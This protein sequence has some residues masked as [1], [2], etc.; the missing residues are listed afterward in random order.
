MSEEAYIFLP[1]FAQQRLWFIDQLMPGT[2][3]YNLPTTM[4]LAGPLDVAALARSLRAITQRHETTRTTFTTVDGAL[5]QVVTPDAAGAPSEPSLPLLDLQALPDAPRAGAVRA[6]ATAEARRPFD[7]ARGPLLRVGLLRLG[8]DEHVLL[9]TMHHI[10]SDGWS[11]GVLVRELVTLYAA[12]ASGTPIDL[13]ELPIQYSDYAHW[14][15]EWLQG[16]LLET[17]LAYWK[18][19]LAGAPATLELPTDRPRSS[20]QSFHGARRAWACAEPLLDA[21]KRLSQQS[22]TTLFMTLLAGF[23]SLLARYSGQHDTVV[24]TPIA[25]RIQGET[26]GVL[27]CFVNTLVL[28]GDLAGNPTFREFVGRVRETALA[29]YANQDV[30]FELVVEALRPARELSY[31]PLFQV[32]FALQNL[33][34][35]NLD[36]PGLQLRPLDFGRETAMF[37]LNMALEESRGGLRGTLEYASELFDHTTIMRMLGHFTTLLASVAADP[38]RRLADLPLLTPIER[39]QLLVEWNATLF[40]YPRDRCLHQLFEAQAART[41]DAVALVY[42]TRD[43]GRGTKDEGS[44]FVVRPSSFVAHLT[45]AELDRRANQLARHLRM[46]GVGPQ[47]LVTLC[48]ER[49][50]ELVVGLLGVLKAG[51]AFLPLDPAYPLARLN[52]MLEDSQAAVLITMSDERRATSDEGANSSS[53]LRPASCVKTVDLAADWPL[54]AQQPPTPPAS[55]VG[56]ADLAY[57][58]YTSGST[59]QP[60]GVPIRHG[61]AVPFFLWYQEYFGLRA[62]DRVIQ[63]HSLSFDFSTWEIFE[64]LIVGAALY[65][66]PGAVAQDVGALADALDDARIS[67]L[68]MTPS[69]FSALCDYVEQFKPS[70]LATTRILVLGGEL[71]PMA[72]A[73]RAAQII[74]DG[75]R[76]YN[77]Y[78]PTETTISSAIFRVAPA[79]LAHAD[80]RPGVPIGPPIGN[81][82]FYLLDARFQPVPI[83]L[84]GNLYIGGV[85]LAREY[86][87]RP[88]LTAER[89]VPNPFGNCRLQ[90]ADCRLAQ[91]TICNLQSAMGTRLY[92]TGD[93]VRYRAD[94]TIEFLGR[95]DEQVK[96]RGF[97]IELG[98][99]ETTL[100]QHP[101]VQS[102]VVLARE[103]AP[104][105]KRLVA[106]VVTTKDERRKTNDE[107]R[108]PPFVLRP[109]SFVQELRTYLAA[110]LPEYMRPATFV[111][112]DAL[113]LT[114]N[115]KLDRRALPAPDSTRPE[116]AEDFVA[117]RTAAEETLAR[118]WATLLRLERVGIHDNFFMLGGDSILSIQMIARARQAGLQLTPRQ[119]FQHQ[120]I[121]QLATVAQ[122]TPGASVE[123]GLG[124]DVLPHTPGRRG[125]TPADFPLARLDQPAI[126]R[127]IQR[128]GQIADIYPLTPMQQG[129]L[130][131]T[132]AAPESGVYVQQ[133]SCLLLGELNH[134]AFMRAWQSVIA[135]HPVLR[136]AVAWE[137]LAE[138]LQIVA[139]QVALPLHAHDWRDLP[140]AEQ[141]TR[142]DAL[143][144]ADR[145][146]GLDLSCAPLMRLTLIQRDATTTYL[147]WSHHHLLLD[148]WSV[149]L[150]LDEVVRHYLAE[151]AGQP[152]TLTELRPYRDY[153]A[154]LQ[155]Q[156]L[157]HAEAFWRATLRGLTAATPLVVDHPADPADDAHAVAAERQAAL[158][159]TT[160]SALLTLARRRSLT[161]NTLVQ[162]AWA[163]LLHRYSG[164]NEV[165][166]G[167][168][169]AGRPPELPGVE[170]MVGLFINTLPVRVRLAGGSTTLDWLQQLQD[171]QVAT[172]Q[173]EYSPLVQIQAW[174][175]IPRGQPLF[176]SLLVFENYPAIAGDAAQRTQAGLTIQQVRTIP[177]TNYPLMLVAMPGPALTLRLIYDH[178]R[179]TPDVIERM[180]GHLETL[181]AGMAAQ[182]ERRLETLP[183]LTA[184]ERTQLLDAEDGA[185]LPFPANGGLHEIFAA[186]AS[187]TPDAVALVYQTADEGRRTKDKS[188]VLHLTYAELDQRA[189][190][191]AHA[192]QARGVGPEVR[193]G[194]EATRSLELVIGLL[195]IL[196]AGG[197]YLPLDPSAPP[198]RHAFML[199]DAQA[200][201]LITVTTDDGR[202]TTDEGADPSLVAR[203]SSLVNLH[204]IDLA[205]DWPAIA[206]QPTTN[207]RSATT[208]ANLAYVLYTSGSTGTPKAVLVTHANVSRLFAATQPA[209]QFSADDVW[210]L[211]HSAA[212]DFSVWELWGALAYGGRLVV[213]PFATS[214]APDAFFSLLRDAGVTVLNQTPA[215]FRQLMTVAVAHDDALALRL[216][217]FGGEALDPATLRPWVAR[218][219]DERPQLV[220][221]YGITETTVH[222]TNWPLKQADLVHTAGSRIGRALADLRSYL[223]DAR[224]RLVPIGVPGELYVGGAGVT[225]GYLGRPDL[226]AERFVPN[227][228]LETTDDHDTAPFVL[229][230]SSFVRLYKT[231]DLARRLPDGDLEYLGRI[232]RQVQLRGFRVELGEIEAALARHPAVLTAVVVAREDT[233]GERRLVAYVVPNEDERR[234]TKDESD[235][236][237]LVARPSSIVQELRDHLGQTLP[238]YMVPS[239]FVLLDGLP[240]TVN[241]KLDRAALPAP[242]SQ[243]SLD[244]PFAAAS[245]PQEEVL[246]AIWAQV[247]GHEQVGVDDQFFALGG[248]SI[249]SIQVISRARARGLPLTLP[250]LF[251]HLTIRALA[252]ELATAEEDSAPVVLTQPFDLIND[253][254]RAQLPDSIVDAYPLT[255]LQAGMLF[256]SIYTPDSTAYH[257]ISSLHLRAPFDEPALRVAIQQLAANHP[258][259]RTAFDLTSYGEPLQLVHRA[260][261]VPLQVADL[262][263]LPPEQHEDILAAW[264]AAEQRRP[265][266][267]ASPP[268]LRFQ[269][270]RRSAETFQFSWA[271]HHAILDGWSVASLLTELFQTYMALRRDQA[272]A[273]APRSSFR[274]FVAL[275][276]ATLASEAARQFWATYLRDSEITLLPRWPIEPAARQPALR[277]H[278]VPIPPEVSLGLARLAR[279]AAV[280]LKSVLLAAHLRVMALFSGQRDLLTGLIAN[281]RPE[282]TDGERVLG[283]FLNTQPFRQQLPGGTWFELVQAVFANEYA[284]LPYRRYP[285]GE[286]QR[287]N[288]G[289]PL[290][291]TAFNFVH[292]HVYQRLHAVG[293]LEVLDQHSMEQTNLLLMAHFSR[294][295]AGEQVQLTLNADGHVI[296]QAQLA[297]IA[298]GY[299]RVLALMSAAPASRYDAHHLLPAAEYARLLIEW[300]D[301][302]T[303]Y[304]HD[305]CLHELFATQAARTPDAIALVCDEPAKQELSG[306]GLRPAACVAQLTYAE[307]DRRANQLA[308][309]LQARG[310]GPE[311]RVSLCMERSINM[312]VGLLGILKAGGAYVPLDPAYPHARLEFMHADS[313]AGVL[314]TALKDEG[315]KTEDEGADLPFAVRRS[316]FVKTVDLAADWP[317]IAQAD[318]QPPNSGAMPDNLAYVIYTSGSTGQP[319]GV[320]I[321]QRALVN[322]LSALRAAPGLTG[323]DVLL[324]VT[325]IAFDIAGLELFLPLLCGARVELAPRAIAMD[326]HQLAARLS[327]RRA[328]IMQATP[329][330]WRMLVAAGWPGDTQLTI[331]CGGEALPPDLADQLRARGAA[332]W[333]LYGPTE[334]TIWSAVAHI[335]A[336][337]Q[338]VLGR[339]IANTQIYLLD[340]WLH[341]V[342]VGVAGEVYIGGAGLARGYH[343]RPEL[344]AERFVPNPFV[345]ERR[346]T[347]D[348]ESDSSFVLRPSSRLYATGDL[349]RYRPDGS[350]DFLGRRDGQIKLRGYRI[351]LGEIEALLRSH[352]QVQS[353]V[354]L[355]REDAPGERRLVAYVVPNEDERRRTNDESAPS[356]FV[357][358]PPS[359]ASELRAFLAAR[360]PNYMV[361]S[362][363]VL[364]DAL[365]LTANGKLDRHALP[366]PDRSQPEP[367]MPFVAPRT[368]VEIQLAAIWCQVLG[369]DQ[370]GVDDD[371][372]ALGGDSILSLQIIAYA[373]E[374][375]IHLSTH[376]VFEHRTIAALAAHAELHAAQAVPQSPVSGVVP[377]TPIQRWFFAQELPDPQ[378]FNQARLLATQPLDRGLLVQAV[379]HLLAHHDALRLRFTRGAEGWEQ[380][381]AAVENN[382]VVSWLDL[383]QLAPAQHSRV[384]EAAAAA[385][386]PSLD[387]ARGPLV[388][389][390]YIDLGT[391]QPGRLLLIVHHLAINDVAWRVLLDDLQ[392]A[393]E[394]LRQA[395]PVA[396]PAKT[397]AFQAWAERLAAYAQT[398]ALRDELVSWL[399]QPWSRS[400][401]LPVD[402][403]GANTAATARTLR[404]A[405]DAD[406]TA[407]LLYDVPQVYHTQINDA[408]LAALAQSFRR[409]TGAASLLLD[410][411]GHGREDLFA[412]VDLSRTVG[413]FTTIFP[414]RLEL[415][416]EA[417]PAAALTTVKEQLRSIPRQG[418]GYGLLRYLSQDAAVRDA[419]ANLPPAEVSFSYLGQVDQALPE[420]G[421][422]GPASE[423][424][425]PLHS[426]HGRRSHLLEI[427]AIVAAGQLE[428]TWTYSAAVH[429]AATITRLAEDTLTALRALIAH[430]Q[431]PDAGGF[432]PSDFPLLGM[433]QDALDKILRQARFEEA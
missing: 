209:Y 252:R 110:R 122:P 220:N 309:H 357:L 173:Y 1:S 177:Q 300:N 42:E 394:Q 13:P 8:P 43:E 194:I 310:V 352:A 288:G 227:P 118:V 388:R 414:V 230:P 168:T 303:A 181:L 152:L 137:E 65:V 11:M 99:I 73:R 382:A 427:S 124:A 40:D 101:A 281:G 418:I 62:D 265:F 304:A 54:I 211:F 120:T 251:Q 319:K 333:N 237:S 224:L 201:V 128:N 234:W 182:P 141:Q 17:Q 399:E 145:A 367:G 213:V 129:L 294:S 349:A 276:R 348:E 391:D 105:D 169:V 98:E 342:P 139:E 291:E 200:P 157:A 79:V 315:R 362:A 365:P 345:D 102:C 72:L 148:G 432:T 406:A 108:D 384:I 260:V 336:D 323:Q 166:F 10:V 431:S 337:A 370:V 254:V 266:D 228:F 109:S 41:P 425:G 366:A 296:G 116:L 430:C 364:L 393:Y 407:A 231:G 380:S 51:G 143:L 15:R 317:A 408:L 320:A 39:H 293:G 7:L 284:L 338:V 187:R 321:P 135:R 264:F 27:G 74:P 229:R 165:V 196:K 21:L 313:R 262:R 18:A 376:H 204:V 371:F 363:F 218:Y 154:W 301:T 63:Y 25:N 244:T 158:A 277:L 100:G 144:R 149:P 52:F 274:D 75:C 324:A 121:A 207:P 283:L 375:G 356:S 392:T 103:D 279:A 46:L 48:V 278:D 125:S 226:T 413:W 295:H 183:L 239:A 198:E 215:A 80:D 36:V 268:L 175:G 186:Q 216:V 178:R 190:Q 311:V 64:A 389:V 49:S 378:H 56:P 241:G 84:P 316:S 409:W 422:F 170:G 225:R 271:E 256:H 398:P 202:R 402:E 232:D 305:R 59:G 164:A 22:H 163:L 26:E 16:E 33:P 334:T 153:I 386:Q 3:A 374:A 214:R 189:N 130:F 385:L 359:F 396:L 397:T 258:L 29:A 250:Q 354:V 199:E 88:A 355:A 282:T 14:Q 127:L 9:L 212:F 347:N 307:L 171:Q 142:L 377:L 240:L 197:A 390:A 119:V 45:Y 312:V 58:I 57:M 329:A 326:G 429:H 372:F 219:G 174:S 302:T 70:A 351:E 160:T 273:P 53:V 188:A 235:S 245:T 155:R 81:T 92:A 223:L 151:C 423:S 97:R 428:L 89:F 419:L 23:D 221:M 331:L 180:L 159:E 330:T 344:T 94:G 426:P 87:G 106:Y 76:L 247:L 136:S 415:P 259:L 383:T 269:I 96:L 192:L 292:F 34:P 205:S 350:I 318:T 242:D 361:P 403:H 104:G 126:D 132:L 4:H 261:V 38:D 253:A 373:R 90:I 95:L 332:L 233:P 298:D 395:A 133:V 86:F 162:G 61:S 420:R 358:R 156:D 327:S 405:L 37:D 24:G 147:L 257:N 71:F 410:L 306:F 150:V 176:E 161:L 112:L 379:R 369:Y 353:S 255:M 243:R 297:L 322:A 107:E 179:F 32:M 285:L 387:L 115:G 360:L 172:R 314:L 335:A 416:D 346:T 91:S 138:P 19:Q 206:Q 299:A 280:P 341:P 134:A 308:H 249:S 93:R 20:V 272:G 236:S 401:H 433:S 263:H 424:A 117:P 328:T 340:H 248:D 238:S 412:D 131:H 113:P 146:R 287:S 404:V 421:L 222:V 6:L 68:N 5:V 47:V 368:A 111:L 12:Y 195:G 286:L 2:P 246:A 289:R 44:G 82:Q 217:I 184:A 325:T 193:V 78:G 208:P 60:K 55:A 77:E 381:N 290:I 69:Q 267:W 67:V 123:Q 167:S 210:T 411:A 339:P 31:N 140:A 343:E 83:G 185:L 35:I 203:R 191:L 85:G 28:R 50:L 270:H 66:V 275:E 417:D 30:P 114:A 400:A